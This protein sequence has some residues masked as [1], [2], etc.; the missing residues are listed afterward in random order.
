MATIRNLIDITDHPDLI[1]VIRKVKIVSCNNEYDN[2]RV[3]LSIKVLHFIGNK[4]LPKL[5]GDV[6][7][8]AEN[9]QMINPLTGNDVVKD[10]KGEYPEGSIGEYDF[11]FGLV[12]NNKANQISLEELYVIKR[13]DKINNKLYN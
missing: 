4:P 12:K 13:V 11:L 7:L 3:S 10:E 2:N 5:D 8:Y 6:Y 9:D 1:N